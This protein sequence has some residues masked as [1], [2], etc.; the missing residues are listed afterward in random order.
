MDFSSFFDYQNSE[1][2]EMDLTPDQTFLPNWDTHRWDKL[3]THMQTRLFETG[4][5]VIRAGE[6]DRGIHLVS[7]GTLDIMIPKRGGQD[8][9]RFT[10]AESGSVVGEEAFLDGKPR[11]ASIVA[12][13]DCQ[14][15]YM[16]VDAFDIFA[17]IEP[18]LA[19]EF[20]FDLGRIVSLKLRIT[21]SFISDWVK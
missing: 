4:E 9:T 20:L 5:Y 21:T 11:S 1:N 6:I 14:T 18:E 12:T 8:F 16:S 2:S 13:T 19:R 10:S 7:F 15:F 17:A 3:F